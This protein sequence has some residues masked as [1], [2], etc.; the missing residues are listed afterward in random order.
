MMKP[1]RLKMK[2]KTKLAILFSI[3]TPSRKPINKPKMVSDEI[4]MA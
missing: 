2:E 4:R 1:E 3:L